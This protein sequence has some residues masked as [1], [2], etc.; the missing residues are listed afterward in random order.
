MHAKVNMKVSLTATLI[1]KQAPM[2]EKNIVYELLKLHIRKMIAV[3]T[4]T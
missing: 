4:N 2:K 3:Q 1:K